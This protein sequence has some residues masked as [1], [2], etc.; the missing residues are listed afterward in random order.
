MSVCWERAGYELY[1]MSVLPSAAVSL[2]KSPA[3]AS[4]WEK[5]LLIT[6]GKVKKQKI[7]YKTSRRLLLQQAESYR[8]IR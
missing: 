8:R 4:E 7:I 3:Y 6:S 1:Q 5:V 2:S